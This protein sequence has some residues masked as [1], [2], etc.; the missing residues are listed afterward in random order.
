MSWPR[1]WRERIAAG[2]GFAA[3][4]ILAESLVS[5]GRFDEAAEALASLAAVAA[6]DEQ[7]ARAAIMRSVNLTWGQGQ[8]E[9]AEGVLRDAAG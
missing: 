7:R 2:G 1:P 3:T 4:D 9:K 8:P 6:T 5:Q